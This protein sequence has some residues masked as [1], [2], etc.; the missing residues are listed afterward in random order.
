M[1]PVSR[2]FCA[3]GWP[4]I[5][6]TPQPGRPSMPRRRCEVVDLARRGGRLVR[7]VD[8]LEDRRQQ[9]VGACRG[10]APPRGSAPASTPQIAAAHSGVQARDAPLELLEADACAR[11]TYASSTQP[12]AISS[13]S[14][15]FSSA[16]F[17]PR[18]EREVD[19]GALARP[20]SAAGRR[21]M[22]LGGSGPARRSSIRIHSTVCVS[23]TLCPNEREGVGVVDVGVGAGLAVAAE[24]LLERLRRGR[25]AQPRVA[26]EVVGA[27][28][29]AGDDRE[30]VV[31][32][33]EQLAARVEADRARPL[34]VEQLARAAS[35]IASIASSQRRLDELARRGGPA[36][37]SAG[38]PSRWP[39]SRRGPWARAGRG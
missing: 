8:A 31:L 33:E 35:T 25:G 22:S 16:R 30:R 26:V 1:A 7:L 20:A 39:A 23:A 29:G 24:R 3:V 17:V 6:R 18:R 28:A 37:A 27:D 32:L 11:A 38:P 14:S 15:A 9:P 10:A 2:V 5:C 34:V 13:C 36:A 4:F 21:T 19:V 12:F